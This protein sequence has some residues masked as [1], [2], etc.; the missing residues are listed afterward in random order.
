MSSPVNILLREHHQIMAVVQ[1][2][3]ALLPRWRERSG[4]APTEV[5]LRS[6]IDLDRVLE[7]SLPQHADK[8]DRVLFPAIEDALGTREGPTA[9]MR[10]EH[11]EIHAQAE[12]VRRTLLELRELEHPAVEDGSHAYGRELRQS[13]A[14]GVISPRLTGTLEALIPLL[15]SHFAKEEQILFPMAESILDMETK[16]RLAAQLEPSGP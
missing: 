5:E 1:P 11:R 14:E 4:E 10:M 13:L 2:V 15:E 3:K 8:E 12:E 9:V 7:G 6:L 16:T